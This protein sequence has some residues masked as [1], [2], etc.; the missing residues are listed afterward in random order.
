MKKSNIYLSVLM[1]GLASATV[2]PSCDDNFEYP[3]MVLPEA[4]IE[5]N[6]TIEDLKTEFFQAGASNYAVQVGTKADGS[7]YIIEGYVTTSDESGNYFKQIVIQDATSAIQ[8]DVDA[9]D[10]YLSY[11]PGQKIV[12]DVTDLYVGAYGGLMQVGAAPTS[13]YPARIA[14]DVFSKHAQRDG[15]ASD[16]TMLQPEVISLG[17][18]ATVT[19]NSAAGLD[20]Q[21]RYVKI[22]GVTFT[23]AGKQTLSTSGSNGVSQQFGNAQ[24][25]AILYTSGYSDF[26]DYY[27]PTGTGNVIGILSSYNATWQVRLINIEGLQD[28]DELTKAPTTGGTPDTGDADLNPDADGV[29]TVAGALNLINTNAIPSSPVKVRGI[30]SSITELSTSYGNATYEIKDDLN[31]SYALTIY[32]GKWLDGAAFTSENQIQVGGT[33]VV[34]GTLKL[35]NSTPEMDTNNVILSYTSPDGTTV[36]GDSG[37]GDDVEPVVSLFEDFEAGMPA[38][39]TQVQVAGNHTWGIKSFSGNNYVSMTGYQGTPPFD[40][41]LI[42]P[43]INMDAATKKSLSFISEVNGYGST[44][45]K[46]QVYVITDP[47]KPAQNATE[48]KVTLPAAPD[49]GYS[50]WVSSG[51]VDLSAYTGVIYIAFRYSA[52]QDQEYATWCVDDVTINK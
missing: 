26:Y 43:P 8:L 42:T 6:T 12:L 5:A 21:N 3:P 15:L 7:H 2:L 18:L 46:L 49:S 9:Y 1:L 47:A 40:Q 13:G 30:I 39:W 31:N 32:R 20:W 29:Y 34:Q 36:G 4:T 38:G 27:C 11:Q 41:Y 37:S 23:N 35:Y 14:E 52:T 22:E 16:E 17:D 19:P 28:F 25:S 50:D 44:T 48:L 45:T 10:L 51:Q 33:V 24:G